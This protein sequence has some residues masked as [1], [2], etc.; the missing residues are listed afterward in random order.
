MDY[1]RLIAYLENPPPPSET[2]I[3]WPV[4]DYYDPETAHIEEAAAVRERDA[5][6]RLFFDTLLSKMKAP[7]RHINTVRTAPV[8]R[9]TSGR[10]DRLIVPSLIRADGTT[11]TIAL[12]SL[13]AVNWFITV[14]LDGGVPR[15]PDMFVREGKFVGGAYD[16]VEFDVPAFEVARVVAFISPAALDFLEGGT[17]FWALEEALLRNVSNISVVELEVRA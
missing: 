8:F 3:D 16:D 12:H 2:D 13:V 15:V 4:S 6:D 11:F 17:P 10:S 5:V 9:P 1:D 14:V 7:S